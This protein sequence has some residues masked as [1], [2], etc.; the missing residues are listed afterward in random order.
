LQSC[1]LVLDVASREEDLA[2]EIAITAAAAVEIL[3]PGI[4][5]LDTLGLSLVEHRPHRFD[6]DGLGEAIPQ[7]RLRQEVAPADRRNLLVELG[8]LS[9]RPRSNLVSA[10]CST[11]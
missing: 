10:R 1:A 4:E 6:A 5:L 8:S 3:R 2:F 9:V 11:T 7:L